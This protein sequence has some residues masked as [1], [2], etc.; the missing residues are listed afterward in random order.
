ME[1]HEDTLLLMYET[2]RNIAHAQDPDILDYADFPSF[3]ACL[4]RL[5][6]IDTVHLPWGVL[7][8]RTLVHDFQW[9]PRQSELTDEWMPVEESKEEEDAVEDEGDVI[10]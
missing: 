5:S 1:D 3:C 9:T 2:V 10:V 7:G 8:G 4:A 6:R